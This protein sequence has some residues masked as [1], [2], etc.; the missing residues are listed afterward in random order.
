MWTTHVDPIVLA[1]YKARHLIKSQNHPRLPLTIW[2][3][4]PECQYNKELWD[5]VTTLCRG[6]VTD[7]ETNEIV[8]RSFRKFWNEGENCLLYTSDAADE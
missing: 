4:S 6:L 7:N 5:D 1:D 2:N 3:Y 8:G